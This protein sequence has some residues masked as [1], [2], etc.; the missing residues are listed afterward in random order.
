MSTSNASIAQDQF[1]GDGAQPRSTASFMSAN[2]RGPRAPDRSHRYA[3]GVDVIDV[4]RRVLLIEPSMS[5]RWWLRNELNGG[6][7]EAFET[8]DVISALR[9][10]PIFQPSV[11]LAQFRLPTHGGEELLRRLKQDHTTQAI[12]VLLYAEFASPV[13]RTRALDL[14]AVDFM[15]KPFAGVELL[16]RV[17]TAMRTVLLLT[18]LEK[19]SRLD[20]LTGLANRRVL[21]D[22]LN[23][24]WEACRRRGTP[25]SLVLC[26]LD[27]FKSISD[28]YG[29]VAGDEVLRQTAASLA[30]TVRA[31][32]LVA[33]HGGEVFAVV[34]PD[35]DLSAAMGLAERF[36]EELRGLE[37]TERGRKVPV[38]ASVGVAVSLEPCQA[39]PV[40]LLE[41]AGAALGRSKQS[42]QNARWFWDSTRQEPAP[43][44]AR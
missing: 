15:C 42:G 29:K 38:T 44:D 39:T 21:E 11:I 43:V 40:E 18:M 9:A 1:P 3:A 20:G 36:R 6:Q 12:P 33:R 23:W 41:W 31:S 32:D 37:I 35:C 30:R 16:A 34:A 19:R 14:G 28:T 25:L 22:H 24:A 4:P 5:E 13:E 8:C 2:A 10:I 26:N 27:H 7:M 17:R